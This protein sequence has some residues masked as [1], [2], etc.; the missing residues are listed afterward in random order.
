MGRVNGKVVFVPFTAP[1]DR[2]RVEVV[3]EKRDYLEAALKAIDRKS[4]WRIEPFCRLFGRCGGCHLQHLRY[5]EQIRIK[6]RALKESLR[7][8]NRDGALELFP[9]IPSPRDREYRVRS[10]LKAGWIGGRKVLGFFGLRTHRLVEVKECPLLH[11]PA[12]EILDGLQKWLGREK[13]EVFIQ[14]VNLQ[15]SPDEEKGIITLRAEGKGASR[16]T[17]EILQK[18]PAIKG[19]VVQGKRKTYYGDCTLLYQGPKIFA[20]KALLFRAN[21]DSFFQVNPYQN[22]NLIRQVVEWANL[23]G[24]EKVVDFYCGAGNLT[25]PLAQRALKVW[26]VDRDRK[27]IEKAE[28]NARENGLANCTFVTAPADAG[29]LDLRR[30]SDSIDL[31]VLDPPRAGAKAVLDFLPLLQ[32]QKIIYVSCEPPTL[33]RDL[34]RLEEIGYRIGRIQPLDMFPQT[35]HLEVIA[36]LIKKTGPRK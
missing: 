7:H 17:E 15:V 28:E 1:G 3:K 16:L 9:A 5:P 33:V 11:P 23:S 2:V 20:N 32:P 8:L 24:R 12:N 27:A 10:Q 35:Y 14:G 34:A 18:I 25:L 26:G 30:E 29:I 22:W 19:V 13:R 36:E 4:A 6:E 21:D 31:A